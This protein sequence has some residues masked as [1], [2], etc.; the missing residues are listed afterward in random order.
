MATSLGVPSRF[1]LESG[2][3]QGSELL[4][5]IITDRCPRTWYNFLEYILNATST[6][7][8]NQQNDNNY[9]YSFTSFDK[10]WQIFKDTMGNAD[11][12]EIFRKTNEHYHL[13]WL[14]H[15]QSHINDYKIN[16][17]NIKRKYDRKDKIE[18]ISSIYVN[19]YKCRIGWTSANFYIE[20]A[21][22][23]I[24]RNK[25]RKAKSKIY[26]GTKMCNKDQVQLLKEFKSKHLKNKDINNHTLDSDI[27]TESDD[28]SSSDD[29]DDDDPPTLRHNAS[30]MHSNLNNI[31]D[32][33]EGD[34]D[35]NNNNSKPIQGLFAAP[36]RQPLS[37]QIEEDDDE[38]EF[39]AE[40]SENVFEDE[41]EFDEEED[42]EDDE[43]FLNNFS[44]RGF[45]SNHGSLPK[46][47]ESRALS[48][49]KQNEAKSSMTTPFATN[50]IQKMLK[51]SKQKRTRR[52]SSQTVNT[53]PSV[54][55]PKKLVPFT[56]NTLKRNMEQ[57]KQFSFSS[58]NSQNNSNSPNKSNL[59]E[60]ENTHNQSSS[61]SPLA[62][63]QNKYHHNVQRPSKRKSTPFHRSKSQSQNPV[64][65]N[66]IAKPYNNG[67]TG[68]GTTGT[69]ISSNEHKSM[70]HSRRNTP[71]HRNRRMSAPPTPS[72]YNNNL[73]IQSNI[74][75]KSRSPHHP[76]LQ[77]K[78]VSPDNGLPSHCNNTKNTLNNNHYPP[79]N[80]DQKPQNSISTRAKSY[81]PAEPLQPVKFILHLFV[82]Q[83]ET[84]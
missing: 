48:P 62:A 3:Y 25:I 31:M 51:S 72:S 38:D 44:N 17:K 8:P 34:N 52:Q 18:Q 10:F 30:M 61:A 9:L 53:N 19:L 20:W 60:K 78:S 35:K 57:Y 80:I 74:A 2:D 21:K 14:L 66:Y 1:D 64:D 47:T 40:E 12:H 39:D 73:K 55:L 70:S 76:Q 71:S 68:I 49:I 6:P 15:A 67:R 56:P 81:A 75:S 16:Y 59:N 63:T 54:S 45:N 84:P 50:S 65:I 42:D 69:G 7:I 36:A 24:S 23:Y 43:A 11:N 29:D 22:F 32:I 13:C 83:R 4:D 41:D 37:Q 28:Y 33:D 79:L 26:Q 58:R 5:K 82:W 27:S 77:S 46:I